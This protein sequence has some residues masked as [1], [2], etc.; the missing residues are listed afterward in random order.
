MRSFA[1]TCLRY[2]NSATP[3]AAVS[4]RKVRAFSP[5]LRSMQRSTPPVAACCAPSPPPASPKPADPSPLSAPHAPS[6]TI[7]G[8]IVA[9]NGPFPSSAASA[10]KTSPRRVAPLPTPRTIISTSPP[11]TVANTPCRPTAAANCSTV[12][13]CTATNLAFTKA[14]SGAPT[15]AGSPS[16]A[17][18]K[19]WSPTIRSST[20]TC[21]QPCASPNPRPRNTPWRV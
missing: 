21:P 18:T 9:S 14:P 15:V 10:T 5:S 1:P 12:P 3:T 7:I 17:W 19:A 2:R 6:S 8:K 11:P 4:T 13:P 20:S 16:T